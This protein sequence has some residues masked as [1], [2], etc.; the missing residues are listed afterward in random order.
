MHLILMVFE[1]FGIFRFS[2][3]TNC[4]QASQPSLV[5]PFIKAPFGHYLLEMKMDEITYLFIFK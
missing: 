3:W 5:M 2:G 1:R 4:P